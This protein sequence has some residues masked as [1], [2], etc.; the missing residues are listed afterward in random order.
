MGAGTGM[1]QKMKTTAVADFEK[2]RTAF[3]TGGEDSRAELAGILEAYV[4]DAASRR[5]GWCK[6]CQFYTSIHRHSHL[7]RPRS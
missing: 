3:T 2:N 7:Q 5:D 1:G 6:T 4:L